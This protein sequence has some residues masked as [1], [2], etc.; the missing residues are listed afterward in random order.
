[1]HTVTVLVLF[2]NNLVAHC[3]YVTDSCSDIKSH[4]HLLF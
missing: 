1:M 4:A 3:K 2:S